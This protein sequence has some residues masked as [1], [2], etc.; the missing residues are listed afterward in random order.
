MLN[1]TETNRYC[2]RVEERPLG[3]RIEIPKSD[4]T[5]TETFVAYLIVEGGTERYIDNQGNRYP[6]TCQILLDQ[7]FMDALFAASFAYKLHVKAGCSSPL[8]DWPRVAKTIK[9]D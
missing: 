4:G 7:Y 1:F 2:Y 8:C 3:M 6:D 9:L 5:F